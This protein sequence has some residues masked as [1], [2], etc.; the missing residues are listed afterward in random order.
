MGQSLTDLTRR[1]SNAQTLEEERSLLEDLTSLEADIEMI[2]AATSYRFSAN[3]AY[4]S[5]VE[6]RLIRLR[7]NRIED[8]QMLSRYLERRFQPAMNACDSLSTRLETLSSHVTRA[9]QIL[10]RVLT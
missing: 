5:I 10:M 8:R 7:E 4:K 9:T 2:I 3:Q 6:D 1:M